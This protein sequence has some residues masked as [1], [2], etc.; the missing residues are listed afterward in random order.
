[1]SSCL[2]RFFLFH[3]SYRSASVFWFSCIEQVLI[4]VCEIVVILFLVGQ[5]LGQVLVWVCEI[6]VILILVVPTASIGEDAVANNSCNSSSNVLRNLFC[7]F[8]HSFLCSSSSFS[9]S[10]SFFCSFSHSFSYLRSSF[11]YAIFMSFTYW[12][13]FSRKQIMLWVICCK[14]RC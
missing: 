10:I 2:W 1:M 3:A 11:L 13:I 6:V 9:Y 7:S 5:V 12:S 8:L 14:I 4:R